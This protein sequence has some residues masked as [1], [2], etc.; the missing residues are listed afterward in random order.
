MK[1]KGGIENILPV[2]QKSVSL[3][4]LS[5]EVDEVAA[6]QE[7]VL[8]RDGE[9]VTHE[10]ARVDHECTGHGSRDAIWLEWVS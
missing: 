7:I 1:H 6:K 10:G 2:V 5:G 3:R 4:S 8:G 9:G